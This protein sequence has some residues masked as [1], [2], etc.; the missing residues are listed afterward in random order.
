MIILLMY[1][2]VLIQS[3]ILNTINTE[4]QLSDIETLEIKKKFLE[5]KSKQ[6]DKVIKN[7]IKHN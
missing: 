6:G 7:Q 1:L 2:I 3:V 4:L 5:K